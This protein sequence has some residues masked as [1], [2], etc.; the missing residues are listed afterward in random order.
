M[1]HMEPLAICLTSC[2]R[3]DLLERTLTSFIRHNTYPVSKLFIRDD[4]GLENVHQDTHELLMKI[5]LPFLWELLPC[6]QLGQAK[7]IDAIM[8]H[9]PPKKYPL[10]F[11][12]EDDWEFDRDCLEDAICALSVDVAQVRVRK[13]EDESAVQY[14]K[15]YV[16]NGVKV[17]E[18]LTHR[19]SFNPHVRRSDLIP[20]FTGAREQF[21]DSWVGKNNL[22]TLTLVNG[23]CVHIGGDKPVNRNGTPYAKGVVKA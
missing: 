2:D 23:G 12:L 6:E 7:S 3:L 8:S 9:I 5:G 22:K 4:S 18:A 1:T 21:L 17:K 15:E 20:S 14:G 10:V 19:F 16:A 13:I 11:H